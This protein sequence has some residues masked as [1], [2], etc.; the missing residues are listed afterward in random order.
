MRRKIL[1]LW[2]KISFRLA[3]F[4]TWMKSSELKSCGK[5]TRFD[6]PVRIENPGSVSIGSAVILYPRVWLNPVTEWCGN[7]YNGK[8]E[9]GDRVKLGYGVQI[10][11]AQSII[12]ED[13]VAM[14]AGA[15]VVD[16][17]HDHRYPAIPVIDAPLSIPEP[18]R[19]GKGSFL[20]VYC[21]IGPGV[22]IG[23]HA[24]I[25]ANAV[26]LKDVPSYCLAAGNPAR[27][28]RFHDPDAIKPSADVLNEAETIV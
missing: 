3:T 1:Q 20:G 12:I 14:G 15:V 5:N 28:V 9:L 8:I 27:I 23:E 25:A 6:Y 16:H 24:V 13:D 7:H 4:Y 21:L 22:Q 17:I 10:S 18:V 11:A 19:I 2:K 26:V